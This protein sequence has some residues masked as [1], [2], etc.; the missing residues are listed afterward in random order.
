M[1]AGT[2]DSSM[3]MTVQAGSHTS[4]CYWRFK[5]QTSGALLL[6][7]LAGPDA[8]PGDFHLP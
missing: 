5:R 1:F 3:V 8:A 6:I 7:P 2:G 4:M